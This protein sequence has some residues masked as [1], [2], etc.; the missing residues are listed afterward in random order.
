MS[1]VTRPEFE[2]WTRRIEANAA[3]VG[4]VAALAV[5]MTEVIKDVNEVRQDLRDHRHEHETEA[6]ARQA[7]RR[8][9][10][11][12]AVVLFAAVESPLIALLVHH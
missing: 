5:Q 11:G 8:W 3:T 10:W 2:A 7:S 4:S 12:L 6:R 1:D 9:A